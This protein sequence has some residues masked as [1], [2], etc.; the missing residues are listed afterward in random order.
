MTPTPGRDAKPHI[1]IY[2]RCNSGKSTLLNFI[3][4]AQSALVCE[5]PGTTTDPVKVSYEIHDFAPV[6]FIDTAG[7]DD[8]SAAGELRIKKTF[9]TFSTIDLAIIVFEQWGT[10]E[11][12]IA[13]RLEK[14]DTPYILFYNRRGG[15]P[16]YEFFDRPVIEADLSAADHTTR[17]LVLEMIKRTLPEKSYVMPSLLG[18]RIGCGD[19][20]LLVC[21]IDS[22][23]PSGRLILPQVQTIRDLLDSRAITVIVQ[24]EQIAGVFERG[25]IP[26]LVVTDSQ[27]FAQVSAAVPAGIEI[28][29]FSILLAQ[30]KGDYE[31]Y[32]KGL[33]AIDNLKTG[34]K[35][36]I[37]ENCMHQTSCDDIGR[38]KIPVLIE[39][40]CGAKPR[41]EFVPGLSSLPEDLSSY[42]LAIQCGGCMVTRIQLQNRIRAVI[43]AGVPITNYGM[44]IRKLS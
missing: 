2:G 17:E 37:L 7:I 5:A 15:Q 39:R 20:V 13:A 14:N 30:V 1:G 18:G 3:T 43:A 44:A 23:A 33:Q 24:P 12:N 21:P 27:V 19:I 38:V 34:D 11:K 10:A 25:I 28:T 36:L 4:G 42:S 26:S 9:E 16:L 32:S 31:A 22:G 29:S 6:I 35:V 40:Y 8:K 41:F